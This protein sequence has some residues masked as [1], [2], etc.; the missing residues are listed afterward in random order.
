MLITCAISRGQIGRFSP[1]LSPDPARRAFAGRSPR[2]TQAPS[3]QADS[4]ATRERAGHYGF[5]IEH[6]PGRRPRGATP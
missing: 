5:R 4:A 2:S 1:I 3:R 6:H